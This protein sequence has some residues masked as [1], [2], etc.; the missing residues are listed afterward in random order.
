MS[1]NDYCLNKAA[2]PGSNLYYCLL[3]YPQK[4]KD[5]LYTLHAFAI[6]IGDILIEC[7][8]PGV[9]RIKLHWWHEEIQRIY[10]D[11]ARHP[12]G[13][14]ITSH[15]QSFN[16]KEELL[17]QYVNFNEQILDSQ[18]I[19]NSEALT[20]ILQQGPGLIWEINAEICGY[21]DQNTSMLAN[22]T[23]CMIFT[24]E[25][26]QNIFKHATSGKL[27]WPEDE[28]KKAGL[29]PADFSNLHS[30]KLHEFII[31]Q[32]QTITHDLD[33][34]YAEFPAKDRHSQLSCLI[35]NRLIKSHCNEIVKDN[36]NLQYNKIILTPLHKL[37]ISWRTKRQVNSEW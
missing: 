24:Y 8:D 5:S 20:S 22:K 23:G 12:V 29:T 14:A 6:E 19:P 35:I 36:I 7:S 4:L 21:S 9:A 13:K 37:W 1:N 18:H 30:D 34:I 11:Q 31:E 3:F 33:K 26:L 10:T 2:P 25:Y 32:V 16:L 15:L 17:H 28:I 27:L